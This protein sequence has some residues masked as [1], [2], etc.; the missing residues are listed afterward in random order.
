MPGPP[1]CTFHD[2]GD[3]L[4]EWGVLELVVPLFAPDLPWAGSIPRGR[5]PA[6][7][8]EERVEFDIL[9][10]MFKINIGSLPDLLPDKTLSE[11]EFRVCENSLRPLLVFLES[12]VLGDPGSVL[13]SAPVAGED[14]ETE[15]GRKMKEEKSKKIRAWTSVL[16]PGAWATTGR[17]ILNSMSTYVAA[18]V[19]FKQATG[20]ATSIRRG[21]AVGSTAGAAAG[22]A[23]T[24]SNIDKLRALGELVREDDGTSMAERCRPYLRLELGLEELRKATENA[25]SIAVVNRNATTPEAQP[26]EQEVSETNWTELRPRQVSSQLFYLLRDRTCRPMNQFFHRAKL[27]LDGFLLDSLNEPVRLDIFLSSCP[28]P[29]PTWWRRGWYTSVTR[30]VPPTIR[31]CYLMGLVG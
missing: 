3:D 5:P 10:R 23:T 24:T 12:V 14:D 8:A 2:L 20:T 16:V 4:R 15:E 29:P 28:P 19:G 21:T 22:A 6:A 25:E 27:Q 1:N 7:A 18:A 30:S 13:A 26:S 9:K 17:A 11:N 31:Y